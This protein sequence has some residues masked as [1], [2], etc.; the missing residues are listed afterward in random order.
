M[1]DNV[2]TLNQPAGD[3]THKDEE[4]TPLMLARL[5]WLA[6]LVQTLLDADTMKYPSSWQRDRRVPERRPQ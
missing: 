4:P 3:I 1:S 2:I 6:D 5:R